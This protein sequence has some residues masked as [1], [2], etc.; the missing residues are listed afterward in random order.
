M[1]SIVYGGRDFSEV[2]SAEVVRRGMHSVWAESLGVPGRAGALPLP[3]HVPPEDVVVKLM[4]DAGFRPGALE[5]SAMRH[6][7]RSWLC[8]PGCAELVLP[9]D[10][11]LTYR[12]AMVTDSD[13]WSTLFETGSCEVTFT[14]FDPVAYGLYRVEHSSRFDIDGTWST[15]P[16]L[17][18]EAARGS[19]ILVSHPSSG[20]AV[21][22]DR[23]FLGGERVV[24]D[25]AEERVTVDGVDARADVALASD[26]PALEP[27][28]CILSFS[29]VTDVEVRFWERW[30]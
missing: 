28:E 14:L 9:D 3:G 30:L 17:V 29:N 24:V 13:G 4:L 27:G 1:R 21:R 26:F 8:R 7:L 12:D 5:L 19:S 16:V 2:C 18:L 10:P 11:E 6:R 15:L 20:R 22:I 23:E 25:C